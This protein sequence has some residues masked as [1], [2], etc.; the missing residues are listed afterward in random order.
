M[1]M[2]VRSSVVAVGWRRAVAQL[3]NYNVQ[4]IIFQYALLHY[5]WPRRCTISPISYCAL[6]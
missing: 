1:F 5:L 6:T 2:I 4:F 3:L